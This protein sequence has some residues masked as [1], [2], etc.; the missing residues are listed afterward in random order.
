MKCVP[1]VRNQLLLVTHELQGRKF[2]K[3]LPVFVR[4]KRTAE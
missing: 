2:K 1:V 3:L 4:L